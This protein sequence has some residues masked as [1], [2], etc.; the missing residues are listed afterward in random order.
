MNKGLGFELT[1]GEWVL[2]KLYYTDDTELISE[3]GA[4]V[5]ESIQEEKIYSECIQE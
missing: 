1:G 2:N 3:D 5:R 4:C